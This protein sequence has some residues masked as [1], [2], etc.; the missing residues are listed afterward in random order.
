MEIYLVR[1]TTPAVDKGICYGQTDLNITNSF[2]EEARTI[3]KLISTGSGVLYTSPLLRCVT[4]AGFIAR[5]RSLPVIKDDRLKEMNFGEWEMQAWNDIENESLNRWMNDYENECCPQGESYKDL[6]NRV[7]SFLSE[8]K[9]STHQS[10]VIVTHA[11]VIKACHAILE[12]RSLKEAMKLKIEYG[13][14]VR[15]EMAN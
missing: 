3:L 8:L 13:G 9:S 1:H 14:V 12:H 2:D 5:S 11:G 15:M 4:L 7:Q 10:V 6:V